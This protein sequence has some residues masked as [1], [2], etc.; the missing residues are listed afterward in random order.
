MNILSLF[1]SPTEK[2][3]LSEMPP[4][5]VTSS[6]LLPSAESAYAEPSASLA[7]T[8]SDHSSDES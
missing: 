3:L 4:S 5:S 6:A 2:K 1:A 7:L 8:G